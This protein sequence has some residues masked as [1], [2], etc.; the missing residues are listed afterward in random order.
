MRHRMQRLCGRAEGS[1][2]P[3]AKAGRM[4]RIAPTRKTAAGSHR[5]GGIIQ[6]GRR[7]WHDRVELTD[8]CGKQTTKCMSPSTNAG[9][10]GRARPSPRSTPRRW[11][12]PSSATATG[13][14]GSSGCACHSTALTRSSWRRAEDQAR[15]TLRV[16]ILHHD[17]ISA[18]RMHCAR[19]FIPCTHR[20]FRRRQ[21]EGPR[22]PSKM[23]PDRRPYVIY[24]GR[25]P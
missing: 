13:G 12:S 23:R 15:W 4:A 14:G 6:D 10:R 5:S 25:P 17:E 8:S 1:G 24:R 11:Q 18:T 9:S 16:R 7:E 19:Q 21:Q 3:S 2:R 20:Q 22:G